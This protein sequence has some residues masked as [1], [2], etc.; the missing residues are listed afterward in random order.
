[1]ICREIY[2][3][4]KLIRLQ[5]KIDH[6]FLGEEIESREKADSGKEYTINDIQKRI[7]KHGKF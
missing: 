5:K 7:K 2:S 1:M 3:I 4:K 6:I